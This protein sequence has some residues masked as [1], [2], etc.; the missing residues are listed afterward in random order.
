MGIYKPTPRLY[1][2]DTQVR[3]VQNGTVFNTLAD[4]KCQPGEISQVHKPHWPAR[5]SRTGSGVYESGL[6]CHSQPKTKRIGLL[7]ISLPVASRLIGGGW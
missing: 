1:Q 2:L 4:S 5:G 7:R 3:P 6:L